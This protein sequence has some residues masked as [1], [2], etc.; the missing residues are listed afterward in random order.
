MS[1]SF[2]EISLV[3][4]A[5]AASILIRAEFLPERLESFASPAQN[6]LRRLD[7]LVRAARSWPL[8]RCALLSRK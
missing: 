4:L 6:L 3:D 7:I 5:A 2:I 1:R 8:N